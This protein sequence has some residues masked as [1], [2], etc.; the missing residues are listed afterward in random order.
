MAASCSLHMF[1]ALMHVIF[2]ASSLAKYLFMLLHTTKHTTGLGYY[3]LLV[4]LKRQR[5]LLVGYPYISDST[6]LAH[7]C[8]CI[9]IYVHKSF[10]SAIYYTYLVF[11]EF[12]SSC[13]LTLRWLFSQS[14]C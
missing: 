10:A 12:Q 13:L 8:K 2:L 9:D 7:I 5:F 11:Q 3:L 6:R 1:Y 14:L 4:K